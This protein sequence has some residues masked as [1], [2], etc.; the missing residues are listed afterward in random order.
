M[1]RLRRAPG[2]EWISFHLFC[3]SA[4]RDR[5]LLE[6]VRPL[7][8]GLLGDRRIDSFFFLRH[9]EGGLHVRLRLR[10]VRGCAG[11][12]RVQVEKSAAEYFRLHPSL[13]MLDAP[14][15]T[16]NEPRDVFLEIPF[17]PE[18]ERYGGAALLEHSLDFFAL[19]SAR[20]LEL[21]SSMSSVESERLGAAFGLLARHIS[22]F[23][24]DP[25]EMPKLGGYSLPWQGDAARIVARGDEI[26]ARRRIS[27]LSVWR[28]E[29]ERLVE[30]SPSE[31][32]EAALRLDR[33][34]GP[35]DA[36]TRSRILT[37]QI[38]MTA[39][40][41]G[42]SNVAEIY[43]SRILWRSASEIAQAEEE[44]ENLYRIL[45]GRSRTAASAPHLRAL[46]R[47]SLLL[48]RLDGARS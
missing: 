8:S 40:R 20:T 11:S 13:P 48:Q 34:L 23:A 19:S 7:V 15:A 22:G 45:K 9:S 28:E 46:V 12:V 10:P 26:F 36:G 42:L 41:L 24:R 18:L 4:G 17:I 31:D 29:I 43:L 3:S 5:L 39:N 30:L 35:A 47:P 38:H 32:A 6:F 2:C 33:A 27:F 14:T 44:S 37:S 25:T 16:Q 21:L 1:L